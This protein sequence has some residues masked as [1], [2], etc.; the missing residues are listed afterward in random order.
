MMRDTTRSALGESRLF[1]PALASISLLVLLGC[2]TRSYT[3]TVEYTLDPQVEVTPGQA[4]DAILALRD[5]DAALP[6][7]RDIAYLAEGLELGHFEKAAWAELPA[8]IVT[9]ELFDALFES[10][11]F[12]DV[13]Y[14]IDISMPKYILTGELRK[15]HVD[16]TSQP[17]TAQCEVHLQV[18]G[19]GAK[20][21][22]ETLSESEPL[23]VDAV[24]AAPEAMSAA[25]GRVVQRAAEA[26]MARTA[27]A[28]VTRA[29]GNH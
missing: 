13:G 6:Y 16:R 4:T 27:E 2:A 17:W 11:A 5:L 22:S 9:R 10:G 20:V 21:W 25:L 14:A 26:I 24:A 15:F 18:R 19:E 28:V 8:D 23:T 1:R 3:R 7:K 12:A 29:T